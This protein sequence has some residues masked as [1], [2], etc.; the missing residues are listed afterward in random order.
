MT[1][2]YSC[3]DSAVTGNQSNR[4]ANRA[5]DIIRDLAVDADDITDA[6][7]NQY[8]EA[9]HQDALESK[10]FTL[11]NDPAINTQLQ[12]AM[13]DLLAVRENP[14]GIK[15]FIYLLDDKQINAFTFG[16]SKR[17]NIIHCIKCRFR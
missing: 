11:L 5:N 14:S 12:K 10:T 1:Y 17:I 7:Q 6:V 13:N 8:G 9:F 3:L 2:S 4:I 15:Y 16:G